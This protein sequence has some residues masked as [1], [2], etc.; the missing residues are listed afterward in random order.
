MVG[1]WIKHGLKVIL[2]NE[3]V[4]GI[5]LNLECSGNLENPSI[6]R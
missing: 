3:K 6:N 2:S 1:L 5:A 4:L